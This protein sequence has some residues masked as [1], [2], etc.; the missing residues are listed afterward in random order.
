MV[1]TYW[2]IQ[3]YALACQHSEYENAVIFC[4][5]KSKLPNIMETLELAVDWAAAR[6]EADGRALANNSES[7]AG[8][9]FKSVC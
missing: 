8:A 3:G 9:N 7:L 5:G 6:H 4:C 2:V 1:Q